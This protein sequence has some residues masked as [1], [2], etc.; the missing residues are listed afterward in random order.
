MT[1]ILDKDSVIWNHFM[2][3][4]C[5]TANLH[6]AEQALCRRID[7]LQVGSHWL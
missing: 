4:F 7:K 1:I 2:K 3:C 6:T 5:W